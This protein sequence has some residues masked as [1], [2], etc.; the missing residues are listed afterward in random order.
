MKYQVFIYCL[1][2]VSTGMDGLCIWFDGFRND[3]GMILATAWIMLHVFT[4]LFHFASLINAVISLF[5]S[6]IQSVRVPVNL[7]KNPLLLMIFTPW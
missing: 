1:H 7:P 5:G 4:C 2:V 3:L 6:Q